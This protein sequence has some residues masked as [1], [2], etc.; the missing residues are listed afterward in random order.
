MRV[1]SLMGH[2]GPA[3]N[4]I[5]C[6]AP[7]ARLTCRQAAEVSG[8]IAQPDP[9]ACPG[10][11]EGQPG[12]SLRAGRR[13]SRLRDLCRAR[14]LKL[15]SASGYFLRPIWAFPSSTHARGMLGICLGDLE[16]ES[17]GILEALFRGGHASKVEGGIHLVRRPRCGLCGF[18]ILS[19]RSAAGMDKEQN[20]RAKET[21][22]HFI[23]PRCERL[24]IRSSM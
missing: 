15:D 18:F 1:V 12:Q 24:L 14:I 5:R 8:C 6:P 16:H 7:A 13:H 3:A 21:G 9:L 2:P 10:P 19:E 22:F 17:F 20:K 11:P 4:L 23:P